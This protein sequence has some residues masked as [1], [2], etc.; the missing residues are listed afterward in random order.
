LIFLFLPLLLFALEINIDYA[1]DK[2]PYEILTLY[3]KKPV[4]CKIKNKDFVCTFKRVPKTPVFK[5]ES[6]FFSVIPEFGKKT[7][8]VTIKIKNKNYKIFSFNDDLH[9]GALITPFKSEKAKKWVIVVNNQFVKNENQGLNF[10]YRHTVYPYIGAIDEDLR[11]VNNDKTMDVV[12]YFEILSSYKKGLNVLDEIDEF[13]KK[14][15]NSVFVSDILYLKLKLL[16]KMNESDAVIELAKEWIKKYAYSPKLPEV[17]LLLARNYSK[18]GLMSNA[19]YFYNRIITEYPNSDIAYK[20]MIYYA[21]QLYTMGDEKKAFELYEKALYSTKNLDIASLAALRLAQRYM[22]KGKVKKAIEYYEKIYK[23]NKEF[24]LKEKKKAYALAKRLAEVKMY[25]LAIKIGEDLL[26][27]LKKLDDMYE[28]LLYHLAEWSYKAGKYELSLKFINKYLKEFPYGDYSDNIASL[29]DRV[30]FEVP[31]ENLTKKLA[32]IDKVLKDYKNTEI[33]K[34]ALYKKIKIL[35]KL[36]KYDEIL[37]LKDEILKIPDSIFKNKKEF[38]K[39]VAKEYALELLKKGNCQKVI[40]LVKEY[41]LK[42]GNDEELYECAMKIKDCKFASVIPNK[43]LDSPNDETFV[44]WM[45]RKIEA[46]WC[47]KDYK[48]VVIAVDDLCRV[49]KNCYKYLNYKFFALWNLGR[50]KEALKVAKE[51]EKYP[52]IKN[53]DAYI[54]IVNWALQNKDYLLAATYAKKIIDLQNRFKSYP[55]SPF[56]DFVYAKY[57][58]NKQEAIKVLK[59]LIKRVQGEDLARAYF[60]LSNLTGKKEYLKKCINV[61][62]SK[63]WKGLCKDALKLF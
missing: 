19:S 53:T 48:N 31:E 15:P 39:K 41:K 16:D 25:D 2:K 40:K 60:M 44:K 37:K 30:L 45:K 12:K 3:S 42:L 29:R 52:N 4:S 43:Y 59:N 10:Y 1:T 61:K 51:L 9:T 55:Y 21:D 24:L 28:P 36:K 18:I 34:K 58:K 17:L 23:A 14:Y 33:A 32:A 26:K 8:I 47:M 20:A 35:E 6:R 22:D 49:E 38:I 7:F 57:S 63:L 50:Y 62:D 13:V 5:E 54:K 46:L 56:V 11:P 27:R